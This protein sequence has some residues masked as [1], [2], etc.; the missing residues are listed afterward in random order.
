MRLISWKKIRSW[1]CSACGECCKIFNVPLKGDEYAIITKL[2]G[3]EILNFNKSPGKIFLKRIKN[4]RCIFQYPLYGKWLCGIQKI[5][6]I[7]CKLFP[8]VIL[9]STKK[10]ALYIYKSTPYNVL[11]DKSC[12]GIKL[13]HPS[14]EFVF[15]TIPEAIELSNNPQKKHIYLT[16]KS[17]WSS[18]N[19]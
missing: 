13:G 15:K 7:A 10:E 16:S 17:L 5:K 8:F 1:N 11:I 12:K 6:P 4:G 18:L 19:L 2:Y 3:W 9:K 14:K